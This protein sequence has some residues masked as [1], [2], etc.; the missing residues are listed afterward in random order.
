MSRAWK[1]GI[2]VLAVFV[3][4]GVL[5]IP[6][7]IRSVL[8]L[9]RASATEE[10][11]R[12]S[13]IQAPISTPTDTQVTAQLF[14]VSTT[15][16]AT[17]EPVA[18]ALP[19]SADPVQ[20]AKQLIAA[21]ITQAPT[22][23]QSALPAD[24]TLLQFYLLPGGTAIADFSDAL[25]TKTPSGILSERL[26]VDSIVR[27]LGAGVSDVHQLK[28]L[29]HGQ[30]TETLA[31]HLDLTGFFPVAP[32]EPADSPVVP[33]SPSPAGPPKPVPAPSQ[34]APPSGKQPLP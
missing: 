20:R 19:L 14:W 2:A 6:A 4:I 9:R 12:H 17:L 31:G 18:V 10:Q 15:V 3:L 16:L 30:Q 33:T 23:A 21:L 29:I 32:P 28:I 1:I 25:G 26:A 11:A 8:R 13:I 27:T 34:T 24:A 5:S 7:L 22:P